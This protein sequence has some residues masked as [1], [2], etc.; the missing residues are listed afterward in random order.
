MSITLLI[1]PALY[2]APQRRSPQGRKDSS[3]W[4]RRWRQ[5]FDCGAPLNAAVGTPLRRRR[6]TN[7]APSA[8]SIYIS[9]PWSRTVRRDSANPSPLR[10]FESFRPTASLPER[11]I[12]KLTRT[13]SIRVRDTVTLIV[14]SGGCVFARSASLSNVAS[15]PLRMVRSKMRLQQLFFQPRGVS[16]KAR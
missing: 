6:V 3:S 5:P 4:S 11:F 15:E 1:S 9:P 12:I 14:G 16:R 10:H 7:R 8:G 2:S 13:R